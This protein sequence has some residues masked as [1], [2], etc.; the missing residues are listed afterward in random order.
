[1]FVGRSLATRFWPIYSTVDLVRL[2]D[3][4][5]YKTFV[6]VLETIKCQFE[7]IDAWLDKLTL[8]KGHLDLNASYAT[9]FVSSKYYTKTMEAI[10]TLQNTRTI[11][12][13][14]SA[15]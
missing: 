4:G 9:Y 15:Q 11:K 3:Q 8:L 10:V 2:Y 12:E 14:A 1:M 6:F 5:F 7:W 13:E